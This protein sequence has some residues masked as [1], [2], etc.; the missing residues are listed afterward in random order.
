MQ[1]SAYVLVDASHFSFRVTRQIQVYPLC[2]GWRK[3]WNKE[4]LNSHNKLCRK[5]NLRQH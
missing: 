1:F 4:M 2:E 3:G 5:R